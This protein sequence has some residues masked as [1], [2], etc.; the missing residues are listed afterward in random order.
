MEQV[1]NQVEAFLNAL[2]TDEEI[3]EVRLLPNGKRHWRKRKE[4]DQDFLAELKHE[5]ARQTQTYCMATVC[6]LTS[7]MCRLTMQGR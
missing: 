1:S 2:F 3:I 6:L 7:T 4:F 5:R